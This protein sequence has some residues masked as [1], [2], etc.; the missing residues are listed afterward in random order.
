VLDGVTRF[1]QGAFAADAA[2]PC[3]LLPDVNVVMAFDKR[4]VGIEISPLR[5]DDG[6]CWH[7]EFPN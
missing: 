6:G 4:F 1:E 2:A 5:A 7:G 3:G